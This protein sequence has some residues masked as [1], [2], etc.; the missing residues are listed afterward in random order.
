MSLP[1]GTAYRLPAG[2]HIV[3]EI[4]YRG[5]KERVVEQGTLG[6]FFADQSATD[7]VSDVVLQPRARLSA[8]TYVIALLPETAQSEKSVE[9]SARRPDGSTE[10]L[11]FAK[12]TSSE[13]STPYILKEPVLLPRGTVLSVTGTPRSIVSI[14]RA[15]R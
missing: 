4:D 9:V 3:A 12:D 15:R 13:W 5:V 10:V 6:L 8:D 1:K 11:L 2:S 7:L 14:Y